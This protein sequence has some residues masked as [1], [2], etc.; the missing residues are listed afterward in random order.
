LAE[1]E[2]EESIPMKTT[3]D[4]L[5]FL[6]SEAS[7]FGPG[8]TKCKLKD[9]IELIE[10]SI[11]SEEPCLD[12]IQEAFDD[13]YEA[14]NVEKSNRKDE[15]KPIDI[16]EAL[17]SLEQL[18]GP[19]D[20]LSNE[21]ISAKARKAFPGEDHE[22]VECGTHDQAFRDV[23]EIKRYGIRAWL[24]KKYEVYFPEK[25]RAEDECASKLKTQHIKNS[26]KSSEKS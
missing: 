9:A 3:E 12:S 4:V 19:I 24:N 11:K 5:R 26:K 10:N 23:A 2:E 7:K 22:F 14:V 6:K 13:F 20:G 1:I 17:P 21:E 8:E 25:Q 18:I 15:E 16:F